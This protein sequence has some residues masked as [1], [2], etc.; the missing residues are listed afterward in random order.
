MERQLAGSALT[1]GIDGWTFLDKDRA[2]ALSGWAG[3]TDV[4]GS[5][6][7][8]L[9]LQLSSLHYYQ[10]PD[11]DWV[12]VD[13]T[14]TSLSGWAGRL[15]VNKQ[16]GNIVFNAAL[17]SMS[18]GFEAN[19]LGYH[20]RG[21]LFNGHVEA[22]YR[23]LQPGPLFRTWSVTSSY[24]RN[25][26]FG[27]NRIGEYI[28]LDGKAR[29][30]NYWTA[31]L[32]RRLRA[33]QV[34]PLPDPRRAYGLLPVRGNG[35][36]EPRDRRPQAA[37]RPRQRLLPLPPERRLQLV[38]RRRGD[39]ETELELQPVRRSE[40]HVALFGGPVGE[41]GRRPAQDLDLRRPL[42]PL[43]HRPEDAAD[44]GP[45]QL[46]LHAAAQPAR[47]ISSLISARAITSRSRS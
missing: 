2:W 7:A 12:E 28:Y 22:G 35:P 17:G 15:Y 26:D 4:R 1:I 30:L 16:K 45:G 5:E 39:L 21:D 10:R 20:T 46:D 25:Y 24:Y 38:A 18:P 32:H 6:E 43:R 42:C 9:R 14:A 36:G 29:F 41:A 47:P 3:A 13:E 34:Q 40:L 23:W 27:G 19:D 44:R 33:P 31:A 11:A 8:I 37:R